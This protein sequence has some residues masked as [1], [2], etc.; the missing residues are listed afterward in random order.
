MVL[1]WNCV[2]KLRWQSHQNF[3]AHR[4]NLLLLRRCIAALEISS[5]DFMENTCTAAVLTVCQ[6]YQNLKI[7][8]PVVCWAEQMIVVWLTLTYKTDIFLCQVY[9]FNLLNC[10]H[11]LFITHRD[12]CALVQKNP[13]PLLMILVISM[14][15]VVHEVNSIHPVSFPEGNV[16]T[17]LFF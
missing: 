11:V 6:S 12:V 8:A 9:R 7:E 2:L 3:L 17:K 14:I 5:S 16:I 13:N 1:I 10:S 4:H 15:F